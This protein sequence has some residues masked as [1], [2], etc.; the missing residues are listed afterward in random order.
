M[1]LASISPW[2]GIRPPRKF[3]R[4][5]WIRMESPG[6]PLEDCPTMRVALPPNPGKLQNREMIRSSASATGFVLILL[7]LTAACSSGETQQVSQPPPASA[8][9]LSPAAGD[10]VPEETQ[11]AESKSEVV[12]P[13]PA[14]EAGATA[15]APPPDLPKE[16]APTAKLAAPTKPAAKAD[17]PPKP[18]VDLLKHPTLDYPSSPAEFK[19]RFETTKGAFLVRLV[20]EWSPRGVDHFHHLVRAGYYRDIAVFRAIPGFMVQFG[21]H[22]D[23][24]INTLWSAT[25]L[26]DD[27]VKVS[28]RRGFLTYAKTNLPN[29][30]S[31]Q[32]FINLVDNVNLDAMGFA[33]I[34]EV[35]EGMEI[36]DSLYTGYGEG[37]PRGRGPSQGLISE[38]GNQY[39]KQQFPQLDYITNVSLVE[40]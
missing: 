14:P 5:R 21:M 39:L 13:D 18:A 37:A 10:V 9:E 8:P 40:P 38:R 3:I 24:E 36:V 6:Q 20:R 28:N 27:P 29:S 32:L 7:S 19:V 31:T 22:G 35:V 11:P 1:G 30:R 2:R 33:P 15:A 17:V 4:V 26:K 12:E 34:G 16:P 23:P 25:S